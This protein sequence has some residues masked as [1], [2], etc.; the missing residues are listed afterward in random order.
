MNCDTFYE[1]PI[2]VLMHLLYEY[3]ISD[4]MQK[5]CN[6]SAAAK[7]SKMHDIGPVAYNWCANNI[8]YT[9]KWS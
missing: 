1:Q 6:S 5:R 4:L 9:E 7:I 2:D 8:V 3:Y